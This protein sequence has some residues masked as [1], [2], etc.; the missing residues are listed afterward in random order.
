MIEGILIGIAGTIFAEFVVAGVATALLN[1]QL[2]RM[3]GKTLENLNEMSRAM[4]SEYDK[5]K[6]TFDP[7]A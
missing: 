6:G 1:V 5:L 4:T 7:P 3:Q 2:R